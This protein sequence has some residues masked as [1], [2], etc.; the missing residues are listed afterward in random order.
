MARIGVEQSLSNVKDALMEK[1]YNVVDLKNE[2]DAKNCDMAVISGQDKDVM[3]IADVVT[4]NSVINAHGV[5]AEE[6]CDMVSER[7]Q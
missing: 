4:E 6:V 2:E 5:S 3:G 1:G 7:V